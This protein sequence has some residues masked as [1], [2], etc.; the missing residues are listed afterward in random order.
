MRSADSMRTTCGACHT[1]GPGT[2][3]IHAVRLVNS[4]TNRV[5]LRYLATAYRTNPQ[6]EVSGLELQH[7]LGLDAGTVRIAA[8]ELAT[9]GLVEWDPLLTNVWLRLT[10]EGL[11]LTERQAENEHILWSP[12][13]KGFL[14]PPKGER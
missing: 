3:G 13:G 14:P 10:D 6:A 2:A 7:M 1:S 11:A 5:I 12:G 8:A 4:G 9:A